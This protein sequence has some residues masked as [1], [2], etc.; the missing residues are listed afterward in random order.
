MH[1]AF[2]WSMMSSGWRSAVMTAWTWF[3]RQFT[4][5]KCHLR[6]SQCLRMT[7]S[8]SSRCSLVSTIASSVI[9]ITACRCRSMSASRKSARFSTQ[10]RSSPGSHVP[11][12]V[13]VSKYANGH[14]RAEFDRWFRGDAWKSV[15]LD[16]S[17]MAAACRA[18]EGQSLEH[19]LPIDNDYFANSCLGAIDSANG[20]GVYLTKEHFVGHLQ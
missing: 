1:Q 5:C 12:V 19:S 18:S 14:P 17:R 10:P 15:Y 11:Y 2:S 16:D 9:R 20:T 7:D 8:T 6:I 13:Q 4:A 3:V